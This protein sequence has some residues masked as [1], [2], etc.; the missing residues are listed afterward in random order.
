MTSLGSLKV[1]EVMMEAVNVIAEGEVLQ[2][3]N[4]MTGTLPKLH[5]GDFG[6]RPVCCSEAA[7]RA[8]VCLPVV[9]LSRGLQDYGRY[10][11]T[12]LSSS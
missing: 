9:R 5:A 2:L 10:L 11:G 6:K 7:A 12:R 8:P 3:M 4:V 1:L